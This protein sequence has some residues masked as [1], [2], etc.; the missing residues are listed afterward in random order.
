[1]FIIPNARLRTRTA[2]EAPKAISLGGKSRGEL[3]IYGERMGYQ[4]RELS[5]KDVVALTSEEYLWFETFFPHRLEEAAQRAAKKKASDENIAA[6][7]TRKMWEEGTPEEIDAALVEVNR[8]VAAHPQFIGSNEANRQAIVN[9]LVEMNLPCTYANLVTAFQDLA[10]DGKL[11]LLDGD[12]ELSGEN[13]VRSPRLRVLLEAQSK[14]LPTSES[15]DAYLADHPELRDT[16]VS[17]LMQREIAQRQIT[18]EFFKKST[19][20]TVTHNG[21]KVTDYNN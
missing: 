9:W 6:W 12:T 20:A 18:A 15:A 5:V 13:L 14:P 16:R 19:E 1:M 17:P 2:P 21:T 4:D 11:T 3:Q 10:K 7:K 8:F